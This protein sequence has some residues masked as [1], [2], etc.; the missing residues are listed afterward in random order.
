MRSMPETQ[1]RLSDGYHIAYQVVDGADRDILFVPASDLADRSPLGRSDRG[2]R[3][4][5]RGLRRLSACGRLKD[6]IGGLA[7][8][9]GARVATF[10]WSIS[11]N[12]GA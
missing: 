3:P 6:G 9:I 5:A 11:A 7:V 8:H 4:A 12:V 2:P 10:A 1:Y